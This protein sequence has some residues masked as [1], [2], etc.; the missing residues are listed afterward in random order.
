MKK[1]FTRYEIEINDESK[2]TNHSIKLGVLLSRN[3]QF[4]TALDLIKKTDVCLHFEN[5]T[6]ITSLVKV[7]KPIGM[8]LTGD[9]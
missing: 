9:E 8:N 3:H 2:C 6:N 4:K 1:L 7:D 5:Y